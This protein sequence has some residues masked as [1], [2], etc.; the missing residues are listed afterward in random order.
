MRKIVYLLNFGFM[1]LIMI[2]MLGACKTDEVPE[3]THNYGNIYYKDA[4]S[5]WKECSCGEKNDENNHIYGDWITIT[6]ATETS[7]G[8]K[9]QI[10][11]TCS[12]E[13]VVE[14]PKLE[15]VHKYNSEVIN[16]TCESK[17]YTKYLCGCGDTY[18]D[19]EVAAL[20]HTEV[21]DEA[22]APTCTTTGLTEGSHC[23]VCNET[24]IAQEI[25]AALGHT[26]VVDDAVAPTCTTTGLTEGKHCSVC[27]ETLIAQEIV[28]ALGHTEVIDEAVA[29]TC[30]ATGLT[31]G[32]HCSVCN[33]TLIAQEI[34]AALGHAEV[35]DA[36]VAPTCT[37]TGLT[38]G[39]HCSVCNETL[40]AQEVV[41]ALEHNYENYVCVDCDYHFYTKGL[42]FT[43]SNDETYYLVS[44]YTGTDT[45]VVIP[46]TYNGLPVTRIDTCAFSGCSSLTNIIIPDSV[47]S[48]GDYAFYECNS[49]TNIIIP[50]SV[51]SIGYLAF[52]GCSS[53]TNI[54][55]PDSVTSIGYGAFNECSSLTN[56]IIP[57]S[58]TSIGTCA[59][60]G[61][62]SLTSI[63]IPDCVTNIGDFEFSGC[64]SLESLTIPDSVT[65]I[66]ERAFNGCSSLTSITI[67]NSVTSIGERAFSDCKSLTNVYYTGTEEQWN[68]ITI[69][70]YGNYNYPLTSAT[71]TYHYGHDIVLIEAI[72]PTCTKTGLTEGKHCSTCNEVLEA[73]EEVSALGHDYKSAV[74]NPTC[75]AQGYTTH[76][77]DTCGD[78]Y[79]DTYVDALG[80]TEVI[81]EAV[82]PTCT[83]T[84][85]TE[86]KHCLT[87]NEVLVEQEE[88]P[89]LEHN[90][91]N[92]VC[93]DCDYHFY[94]KG[95]NFI[96]STD[97]SYY[98]VSEYT[99]TDTKVVI[100][101]IY[102]DK[103]V[104]IISKRAFY[105]CN[106]LT[107]IIIPDSVTSIGDYAFCK[108]VSLKSITI[109]NSVTSIGYSVFYK[110]SSLEKITLPFV[111][112]E[113][114]GTGNTHFG[115]IFGTYDSS[116]NSNVVPT[117]L[118]E[119]IITGVTSI[120]KY[121][122][123]GCSSLTNII[124][125][126]SVTSIGNGAFS[127]C[128]SLTN[129]IIPDSVTNIGD[130]AFSG[131]S[132]LTSIII[133][134][135]V[136]SIGKR[137]FNGCSSLTSI[138]IS[139]SVTNIGD[140]AFSGCSSLT[141]ITIPNSVTNIGDH[142]FDSC[143]SLT[144][145][146]IP[147]SV[148][149]I[150]KRAFNG[151]SSL[152]SIT[153]PNSVTNIGDYAFD[154]CS[155]LESVIMGNG[156]TNIGDY[157]FDRCYDLTSITIPNSVTNIGDYAFDR[158]YDLTNVY[159]TGTEEEYDAITINSGN[160]QLSEATV[161]Y[162]SD[163]EPQANGNYWYYDENGKVKI[164]E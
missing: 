58:V 128:S 142:A 63:T 78:T 26:E 75:T 93:V 77:C 35:V 81:D 126:D 127:G 116:Y 154:S 56:I 20:G 109:P 51:T 79:V 70:N 21:I 8:L 24:L 140:Y 135:S 1:S 136:T 144:N 22:V 64:S 158:C 149:S 49:L 95:L 113:L 132:S 42:N 11:A 48:I 82:E 13:N 98:L 43:L 139:N 156:V 9:K 102:N 137:A 125:P 73:Q 97:E 86:G 147:D 59:F 68:S 124:I 89:A 106:S 133:G 148:T 29:P 4:T 110:C 108:C 5:H 122:F 163:S 23:S 145:I 83:K 27:N 25:V 31:E 40:V 33:E 94:T 61:C 18:N 134:N 104:T 85:L 52:S 112:E 60:S 71:I 2:M 57:D 88:I 17:G 90:Y 84:G 12:Y 3:H 114:N 100:P 39:K 91:E 152:T 130:Y 53:L 69:D 7:V 62:S 150:G 50:D 32:S 161:Y 119:V 123:N 76:T 120:R 36:A 54:I 121:A 66:G 107:N 96:L 45:E 37:A 67:G 72:E 38:E 34:V 141:S 153:I 15:H 14:I 151:C 146:I 65:N 143:N 115:Y 47:T 87:C 41:P 30:T 129:I 103:P 160:T 80:H 164:W 74:T 162:F 6:E 16:P 28:A 155:S 10:C 118:T 157:A 131:C 44:E 92:Y 117:S 99:G 55:I 138:T 46:S 19:D 101:F 105:E 159:Y 111:G